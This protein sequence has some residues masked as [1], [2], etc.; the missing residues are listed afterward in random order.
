LVRVFKRGRLYRHQ[1]TLDIDVF[2]VGDSEPDPSGV[3]LKV[4]YWNRNFKIFQ[5]EVD[6]VVI[7]KEDFNKW[8][9]L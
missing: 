4:R 3:R 6:D 9:E 8:V 5:G 7:R 2:V 1:N